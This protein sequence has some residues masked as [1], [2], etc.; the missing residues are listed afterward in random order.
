VDFNFIE[1]Q[2]VV[3]LIV[4]DENFP[5]LEGGEMAN[6]PSLSSLVHF[7]IEIFLL[8]EVG[9]KIFFLALGSEIEWKNEKLKKD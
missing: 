2:N 1:T 8:S 5:T 6:S 9:W 3:K 7:S 4:W